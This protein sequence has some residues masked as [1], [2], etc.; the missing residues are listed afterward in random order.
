MQAY[1]EEYPKSKNNFLQARFHVTSTDKKRL[2]ML[3][4]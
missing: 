3:N 1:A 4:E 2:L